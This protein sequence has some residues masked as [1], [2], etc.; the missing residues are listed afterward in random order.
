MLCVTYKKI[1]VSYKKICMSYKK[2]CMSYAPILSRI[3]TY[4]PFLATFDDL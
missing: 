2:I 1:C 3:Y 4:N